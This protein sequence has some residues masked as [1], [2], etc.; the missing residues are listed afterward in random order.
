MNLSAYQPIFE[1]YKNIK[2]T[3]S[4]NELETYQKT[5]K[6]DTPVL[7]NFYKLPQNGRKVVKT[8][9]ELDL[10]YKECKNISECSDTQ[11]N[12]EEWSDFKL[13][14][15]VKKEFQKYSDNILKLLGKS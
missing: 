10:N 3:M 14:K 15:N 12:D 13:R 1:Y 2:S 4:L 6:L 5:L 11:Y 9:I 8:I 7:L